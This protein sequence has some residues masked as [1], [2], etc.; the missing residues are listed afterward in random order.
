MMKIVFLVEEPSMA[1]LLEG[2]LPRLIPGLQFQCVPHDGKQDL[3]LSVPKK[4]RAWREPDVRFVVMRDRNSADCRQVKN[5]LVRL[6]EEAGRTDVLVRIVCRELEAWYLGDVGALGRAYPEARQ[7][8][9]RE[10]NKRRYQDP[11]GVV[12][13]SKALARLVPEFQ[14]RQGAR[15]MANCLSRENRSHSFQVFVKGVE[16]LW[17]SMKE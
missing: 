1:D 17:A 7:G 6:C 8:A 10:L 12:Q 14:K 2:L 5:A 11:D 13:P 9:L 3:T 16:R 4:I 15:R